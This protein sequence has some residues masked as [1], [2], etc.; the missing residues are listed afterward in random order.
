MYFFNAGGIMTEWKK[1]K[2]LWHRKATF[3]SVVARNVHMCQVFSCLRVKWIQISIFC[4]T[5]DFHSQTSVTRL[6]AATAKLSTAASHMCQISC[7]TLTLF[8]IH[9]LLENNSVANNL[10]QTIFP[11]YHRIGHWI[12]RDIYRKNTGKKCVCWCLLACLFIYSFVYLLFGSGS[13]NYSFTCFF[14][15]KPIHFTSAG[16]QLRFF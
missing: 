8:R 16:S 3:L 2:S 7:R 15:S 6:T 5:S 4:Q 1:K 14:K 11:Q 10:Y 9:V 13:I 12:T